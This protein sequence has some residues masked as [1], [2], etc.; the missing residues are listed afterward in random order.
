MRD[1]REI[2]ELMIQSGQRHHRQRAGHAPAGDREPRV[3]S[4]RREQNA[5]R[6]HQARHGVRDAPGIA[7][8]SHPTGIP[9]GVERGLRK[10]EIQVGRPA[11]RDELGGQ[12]MKSF[13]PGEGDGLRVNG[14]A[15][16]QQDR[17]QGERRPRAA[18]E[19]LAQRD[20]FERRRGFR[21]ASQR[22]DRVRHSSNLR[23]R[24]C[25]CGRGRR[26]CG[27]P[28]RCGRRRSIRPRPVWASRQSC[29]WS[30]RNRPDRRP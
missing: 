3:H 15:G 2:D 30:D 4:V 9:I 11:A 7:E 26:C 16:R 6:A 17:R 10:E 28:G 24:S 1:G 21:R 12:Q 14:Q 13:V 23:S 8:Q 19:F 5:G 22:I 25:V 20:G 18:P 27:R 29:S